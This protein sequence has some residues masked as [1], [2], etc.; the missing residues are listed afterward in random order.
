MAWPSSLR[1]N[2]EEK[3]LSASACRNMARLPNAERAGSRSGLPALQIVVD[4][5]ELRADSSALDSLK[6]EQL[7]VTA[8]RGL[9]TGGACRSRLTD[10]QAQR[11]AIQLI[12]TQLG[13]AL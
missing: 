8:L 1:T 12:D 3:Q 6:R 7:C 5:Q 13:L 10:T 9:E 11:I 2:V 4:G